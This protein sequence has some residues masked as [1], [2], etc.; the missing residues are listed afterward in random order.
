MS[1]NL[2]TEILS[3]NELRSLETA[4]EYLKSGELVAIPT[5]TVYGLAA[6]A[7]QPDAVSKIFAAKGRPADHPLIVHIDGVDKLSKWAAAIPKCVEA[8][9]GAFWPGPLTLI[10]PK[11]EHV[12]PI[13]TGG[14]NTVGLRVPN[15]A[16]VLALLARLDTGLAAPSANPYKRISPTTAEQVMFG[17]NNKIAA[18]L[19]GGPCEVGLEST[20]VDVTGQT[21][22][23]LRAGPITK[24][25]IEAVLG[26]PIHMP[27]THNMAVPGNVK[28]HYQPSKP[29]K[30][31][32]SKHLFEQL[33]A[34]STLYQSDIAVLYYSD[35]LTNELDNTSAMQMKL[36]SDKARY[37]QNLYYALHQLD[38]AEIKHIWIELPPFDEQW[39]DVHDRLSRSAAS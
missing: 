13:V 28:A 11:A 12:S 27:Q 39:Q 26:Y 34:H 31:M 29:V 19:D 36:S 6:D 10:L 1:A 30:L 18:I 37:A 5:E 33:T 35:F 20:I 7:S 9:A 22:T 14:Q 16:D 4:F 15:Q 24:S 32:Q 17:L 23:I 3:L 25:Q 38:G 2:K 8:L 21:P